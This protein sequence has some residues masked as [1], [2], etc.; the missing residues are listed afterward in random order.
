VSLDVTAWRLL[1]GLALYGIGVGFAGA[2]LTNVVLSQIPKHS[3]GVASG[4]N[5]TVRQV[6][7]ALGVAVIGALLTTLTISHATAQVDQSSMAPKVKTEAV[8]GIHA[9]GANYRPPAVASAGDTSTITHALQNGVISGTRAALIFAFVVVA[10]G[11]ILSFLIP[12]GGAVPD[13]EGPLRPLEGSNRSNRWTP[14][15]H[16]SRRR[17]AI[18]P[19]L[20]YEVRS[21]AAGCSRR[22][23]AP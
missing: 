3:S 18:E 15:L 11:G 1:P 10:L 7:M 6:G 14:T 4:A 16:W 12:R 20:R 9:L 5:T 19:L 2:Q 8:T 13:V 17:T 21:P 23:P 22:P